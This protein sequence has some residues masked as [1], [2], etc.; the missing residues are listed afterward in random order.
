M[1]RELD[2]A[3]RALVAPRVVLFDLLQPLAPITP[4]RCAA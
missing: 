2:E 3:A 4:V 1:I